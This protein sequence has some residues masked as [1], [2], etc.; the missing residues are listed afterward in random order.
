M[1]KKIIDYL[2]NNH[3]VFFHEGDEKIC[4]VD[5]NKKY[6][7]AIFKGSS[8]ASKY[9]NRLTF[10]RHKMAKIIRPAEFAE[11]HIF[12]KNFTFEAFNIEIEANHHYKFFNGAQAWI[13]E[14]IKPSDYQL[15]YLELFRFGYNKTEAKSLTFGETLL[16]Y[17]EIMEHKQQWTSCVT[18]SISTLEFSTGLIINSFPVNFDKSHSGITYYEVEDLHYPSLKNFMN[19]RRCN[20]TQKA[21]IEDY[22][23]EYQLLKENL[24]QIK[25]N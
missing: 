15:G 1:L 11:T 24:K 5:E 18:E 12:I 23:S 22:L 3:L 10:L 21:L 19:S 17:Q 20:P 4:F 6:L 9:Q 7:L 16:S 14:Y 8:E 25:N 2:Q 13:Q